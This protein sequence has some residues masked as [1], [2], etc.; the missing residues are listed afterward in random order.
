[1]VERVLRLHLANL[2]DL[3]RHIKIDI[4]IPDQTIVTDDWNVL[5]MRGF[6]Y[7]GGDLT[8]VRR[9]NQNVNA[10]GE[11]TLGLVN[12]GRVV[13]ISDQYFTFSA[14]FFAA[15]LN[16]SFVALPTLFLQRV[17]RKADANWPR[18]FDSPAFA[19]WSFHAG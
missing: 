3:M 9:D 7:R 5:A 18:P 8:V 10:F 4:R 11:K 17:H 14:D 16:Q 6:D 13:A 12:L 1:M 19:A 15:L 2:H